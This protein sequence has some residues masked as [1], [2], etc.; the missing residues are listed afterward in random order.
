MGLVLLIAFVKI[1]FVCHKYQK[2][3]FHINYIK[4][5]SFQIETK[6]ICMD[7]VLR[8][9]NGPVVPVFTYITMDTV[10]LTYF[11]MDLNLKSN[12]LY[13]WQIDLSHLIQIR[14]SLRF[15]P[16]GCCDHHQHKQH[17][18]VKITQIPFLFYILIFKW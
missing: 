5:V 11:I 13:R 6:N 9:R 17:P 2:G 12:D 10:W 8:K 14:Y 4:A 3:C 18:L 7:F 16:N 15:P 1:R